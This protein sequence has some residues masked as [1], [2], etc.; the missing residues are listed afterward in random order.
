MA[1]EYLTEGVNDLAAGNWKLSTGFASGTPGIVDNATLVIGRGGT[2]VTN[3]MDWSA[4]TA[5]GILY[6]KVAEPFSGSIGTSG[7]PFIIE[8]TDGSIAEWRSDNAEGRIE[9]FGTGSLYLNGSGG[10]IDNLM[11]NGAGTTILN[12]GT[13]TYV[14]VQKGRFQAETASVVTNA[15]VMGG[16]V[17]FGTKTT[18]G[19]LLNVYAGSVTVRRPFTTINVYGGNVIIDVSNAGAASTVNQYGGTVALNGHGTTAI[20]AYNLLGG[21]LDA[22]RLAVDTVITTLILQY[23]V[24]YVGKPNGATLTLTNQY[25]KD[26]NK[27]PV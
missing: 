22:T 18:A 11:Q 14:R 27:A 4:V 12:S 1:T 25:Q 2:N 26:S 13:A 5:P 24:T 23:G 6:L 17:L 15:T 9:H 8:A 20:T 21:T 10:G 19:T 7:S 3:T 16:S